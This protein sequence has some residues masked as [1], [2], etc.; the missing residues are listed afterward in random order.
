[1]N[2]KSSWRGVDAAYRSTRP[3]TR[4]LN[5]LS[6]PC[7]DLRKWDGFDIVRKG[8][9]ARKARYLF[10]LPWVMSPGTAG[11]RLGM[12]T[13][14]D[15]DAPV[16]Y[17]EFPQVRLGWSESHGRLRPTDQVSWIPGQGRLK[18]VGRVSKPQARFVPLNFEAKSVTCKDIV[19]TV[20]IFSDVRSFP[21]SRL[22]RLAFKQHVAS[23][24]LQVTWVG[25]QEDNPEEKSLPFPK[26]LGQVS[27]RAA[28]ADTTRLAVTCRNGL[29][30][31]D[32]TAAE[33]WG[34]NAEGKVVA[35]ELLLKAS[36]TKPH[37]RP[38]AGKEGGSDN[39]Q[40]N[41]GRTSPD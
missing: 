13:K 2:G 14:M 38:P 27:R 11:G 23:F 26:E 15:T 12:V 25:R 9:A 30:F 22:H 3:H 16:L 4:S 28:N 37:S 40:K 41:G 34:D 19:T 17:V 6:R 10:S 8:T 21:P 24:P 36:G 1:M 31:G 7:A 32:L 5:A 33:V 35:Q 18:C 39:E 20:V 29:Q